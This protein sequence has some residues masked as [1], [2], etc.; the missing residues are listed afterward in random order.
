[1]NQTEFQKEP[2]TSEELLSILQNRGMFVENE[3][4]AKFLL[5]QISYYRLSGYWFSSYINLET[6]MFH[7]GVSFEQAF[8]KYC[9]DKDFRKLLLS[10]L[11][12]IEVS[13]RANII[14]TLSIKYQSAYW[15]LDSKIFRDYDKHN[16]LL[17]KLKEDFNR[18]DE[19]FVKSF[20][21]KYLNDYPPSWIMLEITSFGSLSKLFENINLY[22]KRLIS[23]EYQLSEKVFGSW[24]HSLVYI[25]NVCA[26]HTRLWDR[27]LTI[28]PIIMNKLKNGWSAKYIMNKSSYYI[29]L[30]IRYL[31][32]TINPNSTF[33]TKL[34]DLF[35]KYPNIDITLM[36]FPKNWVDDNFWEK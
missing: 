26:H 8:N 11:E 19:L 14:N 34:I 23:N 20:K 1:M 31:L 22:D 17:I 29:I 35:S 3:T 21:D 6:K 18:S 10:E 33:K 24:L 16:K 32:K 25:R 13:V 15:Y 30:I 2:K 12:K 28:S 5:K 27:K 4:R 7:Q 9:F 36:G